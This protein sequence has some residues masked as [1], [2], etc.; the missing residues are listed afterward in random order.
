MYKYISI[1]MLDVID[2]RAIVDMLN[3]KIPRHDK[4]NTRDMLKTKQ[5][6]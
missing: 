6:N 4:T 5:Q 2:V 3:K 1:Y